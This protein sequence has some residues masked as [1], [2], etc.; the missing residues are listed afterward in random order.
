MLKK[1]RATYAHPEDVDLIVGGMA[2]RP[3]DD[4]L[5]GSTFRCLIYE[6]FSRSHRT[7]RYFYDSAYQP[8][9]FTPGKTQTNFELFLF[10]YILLL[11]LT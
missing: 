10:G 4:G 5:L 2:E 1:L 11:G 9:P 3:L 6:Q 7:D 8:Y